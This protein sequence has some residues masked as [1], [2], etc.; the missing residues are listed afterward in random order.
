[1]SEIITVSHSQL[2]EWRRCRFSWNLSYIG[3]WKPVSTSRALGFGSKV[4]QFLA[5]YYQG[6][7]DGEL[8]ALERH[9]RM[10]QTMLS[11]EHDFS[12]IEVIGQAA[13]LVERYIEEYALYEDAEF[14]PVAVEKHYV[15]ELETPKGRPFNFELYFDLLFQHKP[16]GKLWM[17]DHKTHSSKPYSD[18]DVMMDPQLPAYAMVLREQM[19]VD[20]FGLM[21]NMLNSYD[22]KKP[23]TADKLF[24]RQKTYR[25]PQELDSVLKEIGATVDD[26]L[27]NQDNHYRN[28]TRDCSWCKFQEPCLMSM[29]GMDIDTFMED[30]YEKKGK[31]PSE[32]ETNSDLSDYSL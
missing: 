11:S 7:I 9:N 29:K 20:I 19:G 8:N 6:Q 31:R 10:L 13:K 2:A 21:Y 30:G 23:A 17:V 15:Q 4:H 32:G 16:T 18:I 27:D 28:L 3:K 25:T 24:K 12:N 1:M 26:M 22:Y 5:D 14:E